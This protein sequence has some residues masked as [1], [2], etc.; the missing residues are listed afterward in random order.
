MGGYGA[1]HPG[2]VIKNKQIGVILDLTPRP[3]LFRQTILVS[4]RYCPA[5]PDARRSLPGEL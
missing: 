3:V 2:G 4:P 1:K 5:L